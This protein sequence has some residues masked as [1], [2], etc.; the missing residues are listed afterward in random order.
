[1]PGRNMKNRPDSERCTAVLCTCQ[2]L[3]RPADTTL[4]LHVLHY[5]EHVRVCPQTVWPM[6]QEPEEEL[7]LAAMLID[8]ADGKVCSSV[9]PAAPAT[10]T[11]GRLFKSAQN[12]PA[13]QIRLKDVS[14]N[15]TFS[16]ASSM[17]CL[18]LPRKSVNASK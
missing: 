18:R 9:V 5:P 1:L 12:V 17:S 8:A 7:R 2:V 4:V 13:G 10:D 3:V 14:R 11:P 15:I 6:K 16:N